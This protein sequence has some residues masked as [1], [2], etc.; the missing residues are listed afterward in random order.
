MS[1]LT[2]SELQARIDTPVSDAALSA[3]LERIEAD[4]KKAIGNPYTDATTD[5][6]ESHRRPPGKSLYLRRP[7]LTVS[8]VTEYT[9]LSSTTGTTLTEGTN[10][11]VWADEGRL[12]RILGGTWAVRTD[13]VYVPQDD[14]PAWREAELDI[15]RIALSRSALKQE[16][17]G[18][19]YSF[20]A[21]DSWEAEA[22]KVIG[23]LL[24]LDV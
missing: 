7:I 24:F 17:V 20:T 6:T 19:E 10:F 15:A 18:G 8:S 14:R 12:E 23:R 9:D 11:Y 5:I 2:V 21:P 1:V 22:Q 13:V 16:S 3:L 4:I